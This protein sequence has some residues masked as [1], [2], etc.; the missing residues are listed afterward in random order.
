MV[1]LLL[2]LGA[3]P[4]AVDAEGQ[5]VAAYASTIDA[6]RPVSEAVHRRVLATPSRGSGSA[7][8]PHESA[9]A[10]V[11][12]LSLGDWATAER[13][14]RDDAAL[15]GGSGALHLLAKRGDA[16]AARWLL[17]HGADPNA[18]WMHWDAEVT[19]LHLAA[20]G[21]HVE[22]ARLLLAAGADPSIRDGKH[23]SDVVSWARFFGR[24]EIRR[25]LQARR[26]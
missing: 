24:E 18:R 6:D 26:G 25:L 1:E 23:D 9:T 19:P 3:D 13:L 14:L 4:F 8:A 17:D 20:L 11:A 16:R 21:G 10:L 7:R 15:L 22:C 5:P 12:C 2:A